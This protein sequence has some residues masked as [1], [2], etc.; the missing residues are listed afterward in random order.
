MKI[1]D[2]R[3]IQM[4]NKIQSEA[5]YVV[6]F[7]LA[8]SIFVKT[9]I[10]NLHFTQYVVELGII[11]L[12]LVYIGIRNMTVGGVLSNPSKTKRRLTISVALLLSCVAS[13]VNGI[14]NYSLYQNQY[15]GIFDGHF[16]ATL[17]VTFIFPFLLIL[18]ALIV[19][20]W[21]NRKGQQSI[22]K[23]INDDEQN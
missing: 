13:I 10:M 12:S 1:K 2:E 9:Y 16:I 17:A 15:T 19:F 22:E 5:Y 18:A 6:V 7:L 20:I 23:K 3:V 8:A 14:R 11:I 21:L 4:T